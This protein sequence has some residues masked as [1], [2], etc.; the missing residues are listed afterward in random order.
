M[1]F[2][3]YHSHA[4]IS[5]ISDGPCYDC[6]EASECEQCIPYVDD[7]FAEIPQITTTKRGAESICTYVDEEVNYTM[8]TINADTIL[9]AISVDTLPVDTAKVN[10]LP[11]GSTHP[12]NVLSNA[13]VRV[14]ADWVTQNLSPSLTWA[15]AIAQLRTRAGIRSTNQRDFPLVE[16][17]VEQGRAASADEPLTPGQENLRDNCIKALSGVKNHFEPEIDTRIKNTSRMVVEQITVRFMNIET[18]GQL[19][20]AMKVFGALFGVPTH[21]TLDEVSDSVLNA[22]L[23]SPVEGGTF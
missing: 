1:E 3:L 5:D 15:Q 18:R 6:Y 11:G 21:R 2:C 14:I 4:C 23:E 16:W 7:K 12:D 17:V 10:I 8:T 20:T 19:S 22:D 13:Q 9:G